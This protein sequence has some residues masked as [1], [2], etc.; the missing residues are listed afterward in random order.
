[1]EQFV[2][3]LE[4]LLT[5][6]ATA[7]D[8]DTIRV[9]TSTLNTQFY[10]SADCIPAFVE[11]ISRSPLHQ[12]RQLAAVELRKRISKRWHEVPEATQVA[13]RGQLLQIALSE[14]HEIVRH[15]TARVISSIARIDVP[16]NK[17]PELLGFLNQACTSGTTIHRE[18]GTY[19]LYTLFEVIADFFMDHTAP[20]YAL[21]SKSIADPESKRVRVTTVLTLGKLA[22]FIESEDKENIVSCIDCGKR[23]I[24]M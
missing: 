15:S 2:A 21:F 5:K 18:V 23:M 22:E 16:E 8:S 3:G 12:V 1:M 24:F 7:Q 13:I 11:I 20:L 4:E 19:C 9:A 10:V 14:Q 6:L 17:W